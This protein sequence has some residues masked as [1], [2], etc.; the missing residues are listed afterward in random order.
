MRRLA[1][2]SPIIVVGAVVGVVGMLGAVLGLALAWSV[3]L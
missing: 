1:R 3:F 2:V